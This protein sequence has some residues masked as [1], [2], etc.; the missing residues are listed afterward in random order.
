MFRSLRKVF[1]GLPLRATVVDV[2]ARDGL[3]ATAVTLPAAQR[4]AWLLRLLDAG[5][6]EVEAGGF[7]HQGRVPQMA[8]TAAVLEL[9]Q[10]HADR[11]W[12]LV[13]NRRGLEEALA[14]GARNLVCL[15][16][17]TETHSRA[18][19]GRPVAR[20]VAELA[21]LARAARRAGARLR[22]AVSM[23]W[24]DPDEGI[25]PP[26]R[27]VAIAR[28]LAEQ[29]FGE[30][31]LCDTYGGA[32]PRAVTELL[33]AVAPVFEPEHVGLHLHDTF[34]VASANVL[35]GLAAGVRRF[36]GAIGG[37]G[38]CPFAPG[39][40][41]NADTEHLVYLLHG[42]G[43]ETGIDRAALGRAAAQCLSELRVAQRE[44]R[45]PAPGA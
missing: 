27:V 39:A 38:G 1:G 23:A 2:S 13:P 45:G 6:P 21:P 41:G 25:V 28:E 43:V 26:Q 14:A 17:A 8:G 33:E 34:G 10:P 15:L 11:L 9:L 12:V 44:E 29:G 31:T 3:Q 42:L 37:L 32:S 35:A 18:N 16:S 7:V 20:V 22:A 40:K 30:L 5:V 36:D 19:L 4:A 24:M